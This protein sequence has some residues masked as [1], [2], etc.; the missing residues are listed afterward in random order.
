M[1]S[2]GAFSGAS[3]KPRDWGRLVVVA[4]LLAGVIAASSGL[5]RN[6]AREQAQREQ[7]RLEA[8]RAACRSAVSAT[9]HDPGSAQW[10]E[11]VMGERSIRYELRA[12]NLMGAYRLSV[13]TCTLE[14]VTGAVIAYDVK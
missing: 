2:G 1:A 11:V 12:K 6:E 3:P 8:Q 9:L 13:A 7:A 10:G 4:L 14:P 5:F